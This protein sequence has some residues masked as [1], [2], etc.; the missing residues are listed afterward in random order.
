MQI[1]EEKVKELSG[2]HSQFVW[3][4]IQN[5]FDDLL[6]DWITDIVR[7][8]D[9]NR[10]TLKVNQFV[11]YNQGIW[12]VDE[13]RE[14]AATIEDINSGRREAISINSFIKILTP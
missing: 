9:Y 4:T 13:V 3:E 12:R 8:K 14:Y 11:S 10:G 1:T 5:H 7:Y 2:E 6:E